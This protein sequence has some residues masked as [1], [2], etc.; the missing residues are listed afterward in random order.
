VQVGQIAKQHV[1]QQESQFLANTHINRK[2]HCKSITTRQ[3]I[4]IGKGIGDHL[5]G[6]NEK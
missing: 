6:E 3:G 4:V 1:D 2:E 5:S